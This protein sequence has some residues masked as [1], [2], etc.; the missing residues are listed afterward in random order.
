MDVREGGRRVRV[1]GKVVRKL[2]E[3]RKVDVRE[4]G[5]KEKR[6]GRWE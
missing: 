1:R 6:G 4:G 3:G 5:R 2:K